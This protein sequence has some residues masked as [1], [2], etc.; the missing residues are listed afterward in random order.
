MFT[1]T[2]LKAFHAAAHSSLDVLL[3]HMVT[4]PADLLLTELPGFARP[5]IRDQMFHT[6]ACE[7]FWIHGLQL[8][9]LPMLSA[10]DYLNAESLAEFKRRAMAETIEYLDR[11]TESELNRVLPRVTE[12]W[13]GPPRSPAFILHH[14][15]THAYHHKGQ[16]VAMCR[17]LGHPAP[18]TDYQRG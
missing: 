18:D 10:D 6:I 14:V 11:Q 5:N 15:L 17:P 1:A 9:P 12:R 4:M 8:L 7:I 3:A 2:G 13:L 16:V